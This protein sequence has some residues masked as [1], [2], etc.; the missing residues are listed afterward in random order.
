MIK[1]AAAASGWIDEDRASC[2]RDLLT[3]ASV[4][5]AAGR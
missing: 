2:R 5:P 4:A 3:L 1:A